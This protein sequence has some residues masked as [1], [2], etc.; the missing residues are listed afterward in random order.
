MTETKLVTCHST[1][2]KSILRVIVG[3]CEGAVGWKT[4]LQT[5]SLQVW[6][7]IVLLEFFI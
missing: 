5:R 7:L 3:A 6:F 1:H 4:V 2:L